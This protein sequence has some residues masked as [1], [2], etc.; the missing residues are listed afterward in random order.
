MNDA[1]HLYSYHESYGAPFIQGSYR[2]IIRE[3]ES[4]SSKTYLFETATNEYQRYLINEAVETNKGFLVQKFEKLIQIIQDLAKKFVDMAS[5]LITKNA[6]W[7]VNLKNNMKL[8]NI[9]E[10]Y[11]FSIFPYWKNDNKLINYRFPEFQESDAGF[12]AS[13]GDEEE[14]KHKYFKDLYITKNGEEVF[15]PKT[16]F[17]GSETIIIMTKQI[18]ISQYPEML[19]FVN[20]YKNVITIITDRNNRIIEFLKRTVSKIRGTLFKEGNYLSNTIS[21]LL[22]Q[23][24]AAPTTSADIEKEKEKD[25]GV[26]KDDQREEGNSDAQDGK[27]NMNEFA[28]RETYKR[29][30]YSVNS[31]RMIVVENCYN[32]YL[33]ALFLAIRKNVKKVVQNKT[34]NASK[35][36]QTQ[37]AQKSSDENKFNV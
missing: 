37:T 12:L 16:V 9:P 25:N 7:L 15:D 28:A 4:I 20:D 10:D 14:F 36:Q 27:Q 24:A 33:R 3:V 35:E 23:D 17:R 21:I 13:L 18:L 34:P 11:S 6:Q 22:E 30:V 31:A 32:D 29:I 8:E 26:P 19:Y 1:I 5:S 2:N